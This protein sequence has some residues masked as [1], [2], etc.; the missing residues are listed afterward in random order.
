M[1]FYFFILTI[2]FLSAVNLKAEKT[3][4]IGKVPN[5]K[6]L[7]QEIY[8]G[9][10]MQVSFYNLI[11]QEEIESGI[12]QND[13]TFQITFDLPF[14]QDIYI[15]S[16]AGQYI[17]YL[18]SPGETIELNLE[19]QL[20]YQKYQGIPSPFY[21]PKFEDAF[22]GKSKI[23]QDKF[24][25]FYY[26]WIIKKKI[27]NQIV[28]EDRDFEKQ[29]ESINVKLNT[30]FKGKHYQKELYNWGYSHLF[31]SILRQNLDKKKKIDLKNLQYP[32]FENL[33]SR[34]F[35]FGL[36]RI[37]NSVDVTFFEKYAESMN[38]KI[39]KA[40]LFDNTLSLTKKEKDLMQSFNPE[41]QLSKEDSV[42][43]KKLTS[44]IRN[45]DYLTEFR[46]SLFFHYK[47]KNLIEE[48]PGNI[49][50]I[51][52]AQQII[53]NLYPKKR[54][55]Y[56]NEKSVKDF[57][58]S[59]IDKRETKPTLNIQ[60]YLF[61]ENRLISGI[62]ENNKGKA[63]YVDIWATWC[64]GCRAEFP[65]Y[66]EII[67]KYGSKIKFVLLCVSSPEKTY[68]NVLNS[69]DFIADHYFVSSEQYEELRVNYKVSSLP[70]YIFI[71]P[72][73]AVINKTYRPSNKTELFKL[74]DEV[75]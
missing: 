4:L 33:I 46:D 37:S 39:T 43:M 24:F 7:N 51:I 59:I 75:K 64:G 72:N 8:M 61:P 28:S 47:T 53:E 68:L 73:G 69:L 44:K 15:K 35:S 74:F 49:A 5:Y 14:T 48:L 13:G 11:W 20:T 38:A 1:R 45:S 65:K 29:I 56:I 9:K 18:A 71:K 27:A 41:L 67:D 21:L 36:N 31:F 32:S 70:H 12:I 34:E 26:E 57:T 42:I 52:I 17:A 30:Y 22:V 55:E 63:I 62:I 23:K 6:S 25:S 58:I 10:S 60:D 50:D 16:G 40:I 19:Y 54:C 2:L 3:Y 66:K